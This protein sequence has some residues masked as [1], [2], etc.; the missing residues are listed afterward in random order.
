MKSKQDN[1][2]TS[3]G[4]GVGS[5]PL[6]SVERELTKA[7]TAWDEMEKNRGLAREVVDQ[8]F[9][10]PIFDPIFDPA[11][12]DGPA[13]QAFKSIYQPLLHDA[14]GGLMRKIEKSRELL[15]EGKRGGTTSA[16]NIVKIT[17]AAPRRAEVAIRG[18]GRGRGGGRGRM[19][20]VSKWALEKQK[21][22]ADALLSGD[23]YLAGMFS[24]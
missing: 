23:S 15:E 4:T 17:A 21:S 22:E 12:R 18:R 7:Q 11:V 16:G 5:S 13:L 19:P 14:L 3:S 1:G 8:M 9:A 6:E 20:V 2:M 10:D 24:S